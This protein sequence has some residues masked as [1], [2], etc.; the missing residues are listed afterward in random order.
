MR[1]RNV[2]GDAA[3]RR[4]RTIPEVSRRRCRRKGGMCWSVGAVRAAVDCQGRGPESWRYG[5]RGDGISRDRVRGKGHRL[6]RTSATWGGSKAW[7][8]WVGSVRLLGRNAT[9]VCREKM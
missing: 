2:W 4:R 6:R 1:K 7:G 9:R 8:R 5:S 3:G